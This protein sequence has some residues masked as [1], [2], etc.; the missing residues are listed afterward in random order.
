MPKCIDCG[1]ETP[2]EDMFGVG[3]DLRCPKC[4]NQ[5]RRI[6]TPPASPVLKT[7]GTV[8]KIIIGVAAVLFLL[9]SLPAGM[10]IGPFSPA[11]VF[12]YL[13]A[14]RLAIWDGQLWR[15]VT[16]ALLHGDILHIFFNCYW[17]WRFGPALEAWMGKFLY[18]G[19]FVVVAASS[20][21]VEVMASL[22]PPIGLSGV[23][24]GMFG[25]H[26]ALRRTKDFSAAVLDPMTVQLLVFWFF[27]CILLTVT[28]TMGIANWAHG[29]GALV[30]WLIGWAYLQP[31]RRLLIPVVVAASLLIGCA[32]AYMPWN[33]DFC[34]YQAFRSQ[35]KGDV[36]GYRFWITAAKDAIVPSHIVLGPDA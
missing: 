2:R 7:D 11:F 8:T 18:V 15:L 4:A 6:Y 3:T 21:G 9:T 32:S 24:Y 1:T 14:N 19:F 17:L 26:Y 28:D 13:T 33:G 25:I 16:S 35:E 31:T 20:M 34:L 10:T 12:N 36:D 22:H 27:L 30:G 29:V 5:K 23:V